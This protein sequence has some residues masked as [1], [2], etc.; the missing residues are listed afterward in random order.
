VKIEVVCRTQHFGEGIDLV[1]NLDFDA[2][3]GACGG[4]PVL[5][6]AKA[7][8]LEEAFGRILGQLMVTVGTLEAGSGRDLAVVQ[9]L[10]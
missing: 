5:Q 9:G 2:H 10:Q 6:K 3:V 8:T 4:G 1:Y 7:G